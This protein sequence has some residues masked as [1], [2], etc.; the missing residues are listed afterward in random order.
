[1]CCPACN[2]EVFQGVKEN[3]LKLIIGIIFMC[4]VVNKPM[5]L[6]VK[7]QSPAVFPDGMTFLWMTRLPS[8]FL[9]CAQKRGCWVLKPGWLEVH[10]IGEGSAETSSFSL[11]VVGA[12][13]L[14]SGA[15]RTQ[16]LQKLP[17]V[18]MSY[19]ERFGSLHSWGVLWALEHPWSGLKQSNSNSGASLG[20]PYCSFCTVP[21]IVPVC[22]PFSPV[23]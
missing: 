5:N 1:M 17:K 9:I 16:Q 11:L 22:S 13:S 18:S 19:L 10:L 15:E 20:T 12:S 2:M 4:T 21:R 14:T 6:A 8:L 3:Y 23:E 7:L